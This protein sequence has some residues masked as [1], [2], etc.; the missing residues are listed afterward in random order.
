[1]GKPMTI[2]LIYMEK[3]KSWLLETGYRRKK[4]ATAFGTGLKNLS[5]RYKLLCGR[6]IV[7][8]NDSQEFTVKIPLLY[9]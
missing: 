3:E 7:I 4:S 8:E 9:E 1:M 6:D 2:E 5:V